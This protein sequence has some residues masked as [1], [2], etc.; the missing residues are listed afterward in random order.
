MASRKEANEMK[1]AIA[2][3]RVTEEPQINVVLQ[4]V[5]QGSRDLRQVDQML[6]IIRRLTM[7]TLSRPLL[8]RS[9]AEVTG[10]EGVE[11][12]CMISA[13][14]TRINSSRGL[15]GSYPTSNILN[16]LS[17]NQEAVIEVRV[18]AA[19]TNLNLN[20]N[21][22]KGEV[23]AINSPSSIKALRTTIAMKSIP[24]ELHLIRQSSEDRKEARLA[25]KE[26]AA[27]AEAT[28]HQCL[29]TKMTLD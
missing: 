2:A 15:L 21:I 28:P 4:E 20:L 7:K 18:G 3:T 13:L 29:V 23:V 19:K 17:N 14:S 12:K 5:A 25:G 8:A 16:Q 22:I 6:L 26:E 11:T 9:T 10:P 24:M 27:M 1:L